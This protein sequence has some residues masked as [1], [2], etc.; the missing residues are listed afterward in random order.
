MQTF[1]R[2]SGNPEVKKTVGLV[3]VGH[4][5]RS[6][7]VGPRTSHQ[8]A[9]TTRHVTFTPLRQRP[10]LSTHSCRSASGQAPRIE[11]GAAP[12]QAMNL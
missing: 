6:D 4:R 10:W 5:R 12:I 2:A 9:T 11:I 3:H 7:R 8:I 1:L